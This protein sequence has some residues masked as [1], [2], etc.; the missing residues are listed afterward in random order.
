M[1]YERRHERHALMTSDPSSAPDSPHDPASG[2]DLVAF[3]L[4][5]LAR[6]RDD[7]PSVAILS[8]IGAA[9]VVLFALKAGQEL[10]EHQTS[11][12]ILVHVLRGTIGFGVGGR[13]L[14]EARPGT[15]LQV[16]ARVLHRVVARTNAVITVT[17]VPSPAS[18]SLERDLF[19]GVTPLVARQPEDS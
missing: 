17:M 8:D 1:R 3:D 13:P 10:K 9:R 12:Q 4:R 19:A 18:H 6:W 14:V 2:T 15:L 5:A 11:S 7:G 16:E